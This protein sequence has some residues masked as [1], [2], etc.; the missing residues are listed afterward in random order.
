MV[1][2]DLKNANNQ[3]DLWIVIQVSCISLVK[4]KLHNIDAALKV[5][6]RLL[7]NWE[8]L[9]DVYLFPLHY[10]CA[11][12]LWFTRSQMISI[13]HRMTQKLVTIM[14]KLKQT[15]KLSVKSRIQPFKCKNEFYIIWYCDWHKILKQRTNQ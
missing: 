9:N 10:L 8:L 15:K 2:K 14:S 5:F 1:L 11:V 4:L 7:S 13:S 3:M 6:L 12:F